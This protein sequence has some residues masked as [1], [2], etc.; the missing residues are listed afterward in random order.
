MTDWAKLSRLIAD[1]LALD[2]ADRTAFIE[3][4]CADDDPRLREELRT[5]LGDIPTPRTTSDS[6]V[7]GVGHLL[8]V[9][10]STA[11]D[12]WGGGARPTAENHSNR[13]AFKSSPFSILGA[14]TL[15]ELMAVMELREYAPQ[16]VLIA[17]G[18][19]AEF[20]LLLISGEAAAFV[21]GTSADR[22]PVGRFGRGDIVG[23]ISL[24][25]DEPRTA[26]VIA[27]TDVR[28]LYLSAAHF[29][30]MARRHPDLRVV[31]TDVM[32]D[33]LGQNRYDGL[34]G[35]DI[36][37]YQIVDCVGR[38]GMGVVYRA[39]HL[40]TGRQVA[41]KMMNH[42]LIY[43]PQALRRFRREAALLRTLDHPSLARVYEHF[44]AYK[45]E[46]LAMEFCFGSSLEQTL[47][48]RGPLPESFVRPLLGQLA[49][50]LRYVHSRGVVHRDIKPANVML[51]PVGGIKLLDFG[52][53]TID[54]QSQLWQEIE[55]GSGSQVAAI[56][57]TPRYMAPEQFSTRAVDY[58]A[59][60]YGLGCVA[61][62]CLTG[63]SV[64]AATDVFAI[65]QEQA[66]FVLPDRDALGVSVS[67][68]LYE[69]LRSA[70]QREPDK[71]GVDL[72]V[73]AG[74]AAPLDLA[75]LEG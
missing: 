29:H 31:L 22:G 36:H 57:G 13:Y 38:G 65:V 72:D 68:P 62:E 67:E 28:A 35:K 69:V 61:F 9:L 34:G 4:A 54:R 14:G 27:T 64:I 6:L 24:I 40:S 51:T 59:D 15:A 26:D 47:A 75:A 44:S 41:L 16:Q 30:A 18:E 37:G 19:P 23:E 25:T 5:I 55:S 10:K 39:S 66:G 52:I 8:D 11:A 42:R 20:L 60:F 53:V 21:R 71:R 43:Q 17:Q 46:F 50:A 45:T 63:R 3:A 48:D 74:W 1:A 33:R 32:A 58:R 70:L 56:L 7:A 49:N 12:S 73:L 2:G